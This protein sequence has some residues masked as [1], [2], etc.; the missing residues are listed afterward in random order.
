MFHKLSAKLLLL[1]SL[2]KKRYLGTFFVI[3]T[4]T[5]VVSIKRKLI[6]FLQIA[7][8]LSITGTNL[9]VN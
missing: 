1:T 6:F 2:K 9:F 7:R 4:I 8:N 5:S 3:E